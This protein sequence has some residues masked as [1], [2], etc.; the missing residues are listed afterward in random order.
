VVRRQLGDERCGI[1]SDHQLD[2]P[3]LDGSAG[4]LRRL[5][6]EIGAAQPR[7]DGDFPDACDAEQHFGGAAFDRGASLRIETMRLRQ[8]PQKDMRI[9]QDAHQRPSNTSRTSSGK[10]ASKSSGTRSLPANTPSVRFRRGP[11]SGPNRA[12]GLPDFAMMISSPAAAASTKRESWVFA[13]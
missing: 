12:I 13:A 2:K 9:E 11:E 4:D 3:G 5:N 7:L 6:H 8:S 10:S 1:R